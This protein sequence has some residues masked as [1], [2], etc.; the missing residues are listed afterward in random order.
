MNS[1]MHRPMI[2]PVMNRT[3]HEEVRVHAYHVAQD[4]RDEIEI[5]TARS[6]LRVDLPITWMSTTRGLPPQ[7]PKEL[8]R[9]LVQLY[10]YVRT[11]GKV[12]YL[13]FDHAM[14]TI[15]YLKESV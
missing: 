15:K 13:S 6:A 14:Q 10:L 8:A 5:G 7:P 12:V 3:G 1:N 9:D 2:F 11:E 4:C